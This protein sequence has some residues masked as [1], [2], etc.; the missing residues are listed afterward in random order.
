M[1]SVVKNEPARKERTWFRFVHPLLPISF[2]LFGIAA[3]LFRGEGGPCSSV[4]LLALPLYLGIIIGIILSIIRA[5]TPAARH[6]SMDKPK[7]E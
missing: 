2:L 4:P 1:S 6:E 7:P 3:F 5:F